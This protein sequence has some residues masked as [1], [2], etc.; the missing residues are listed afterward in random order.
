MVQRARFEG[1]ALP[2]MAAAY[3]LA[4]WLV[5]NRTDAEDVVQDAYLRAF[6]AFQSFEGEDIRPWLLT[7]VRN[8]ALRFLHKRTSAGNVISFDHAASHRLAET[9]GAMQVAGEEPS[10]EAR[11]I[12]AD[13]RRRLLEALAELPATF[14]EVLVL[15]ELEELSY[16]EIAAITGIPIGTVMSR[17]SRGREA[18]QKALTSKDKWDEPDAL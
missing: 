17:L 4:F 5:R 13:D 3:N 11:L 16:R 2:H 12:S 6:A 10:A 7:I 15:R 14:R 1:L 9:P 18:L 8:V